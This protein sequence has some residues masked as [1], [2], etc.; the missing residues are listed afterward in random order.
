[1]IHPQISSNRDR[2]SA[3][4]QTN[5]YSNSSEEWEDIT[6]LSVLH[7]WL[8]VLVIPKPHINP[9]LWLSG[10]SCS[11][12][13]F[14]R[15]NLPSVPGQCTEQRTVHAL[16]KLRYLFSP[17]QSTPQISWEWSWSPL[18]LVQQT[19]SAVF[20]LEVLIF[21]HFVIRTGCYTVLAVASQGKQLCHQEVAWLGIGNS[22]MEC[23]S[24][25]WGPALP[26]PSS[27]IWPCGYGDICFV[28]GKNNSRGHCSLWVRKSGTG[29]IAAASSFTTLLVFFF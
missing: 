7:H 18:V 8:W 22:A 17:G 14:C 28:S 9:Y 26:S 19:L 5:G 2:F 12:T 20:K 27:A 13:Y 1:M 29:K 23:Y 11:A 25:M 6:K 4:K 24:H 16:F 15:Y 3:P 10:R 21:T